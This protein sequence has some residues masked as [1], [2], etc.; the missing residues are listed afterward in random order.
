[1][2]TRKRKMKGDFCERV[3]TPKAKFDK[4]SFRYKQSGKS[5]LLVAC[6]RN[7]YHPTKPKNRRCDV[8]LQAH[9]ILSHAPTGTCRVGKAIHK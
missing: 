5:W 6:P 7:H 8:G 3:V 9:K 2:A 4:R 1:M